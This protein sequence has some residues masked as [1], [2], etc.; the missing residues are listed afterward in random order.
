[1][2][3]IR[4]TWAQFNRLVDIVENE[5]EA[6]RKHPCDDPTELSKTARLRNSLYK[7]F[8]RETELCGQRKK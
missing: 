3:K 4:L 2:P 6:L 1:M 8:N 7:Q 5:S